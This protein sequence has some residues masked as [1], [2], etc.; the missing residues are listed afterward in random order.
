MYLKQSANKTLESNLREVPFSWRSKMAC[1][2]FTDLSI[3][4]K[5]MNDTVK[6]LKRQSKW[7]CIRYYSPPRELVA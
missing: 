1:I 3:R 2:C 5:K 7:S 4:G 6:H